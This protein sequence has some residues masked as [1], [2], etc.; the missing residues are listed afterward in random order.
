MGVK[1]LAGIASRGCAASCPRVRRPSLA[2]SGLGQACPAT[3]GR[4]RRH[5]QGDPEDNHRG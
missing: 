1:V 3:H 4:G 5:H 2:R